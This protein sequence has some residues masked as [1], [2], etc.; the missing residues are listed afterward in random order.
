ML[1]GAFTTVFPL[2]YPCPIESHLLRLLAGEAVWMVRW[3]EPRTPFDAV[4]IGPSNTYAQHI[5]KG[6]GCIMKLQG[7]TGC[8]FWEIRDTSREIHLLSRRECVR[9]RKPKV[10]YI[11]RP[12]RKDFSETKY[13]LFRSVEMHISGLYRRRRLQGPE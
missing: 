10:G 2:P 9:L 3:T 13:L 4:K 1:T 8:T 7:H 6:S 12:F 11:W 5:F